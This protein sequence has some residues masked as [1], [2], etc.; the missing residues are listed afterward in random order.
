VP[1]SIGNQGTSFG[2]TEF[3]LGGGTLRAAAQI[4][5]TSGQS[6]LVVDRTTQIERIELTRD[7]C[8]GW[9]LY[10]AP[11][12]AQTTESRGRLSLRTDGAR[13]PLGAPLAGTGAGYVEIHEGTVG[14]GPVG[15][16]LTSLVRQVEA[17]L[18]GQPFATNR[19]VADVWLQLPPQK[20]GFRLRNRRVYHDRFLVQV[21][22]ATIHTSGSVG[23]DQS[24]DIVAEVPIQDSW[25]R[26][27]RFAKGVRGS[28]VTV[29]I[30]GTVSQPRIDERRLQEFSRRL[31]GEVAGRLLQE[32][33][34][35]GVN[36][37]FGAER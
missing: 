11:V 26:D 2:P 8:R 33:L 34:L 22:D 10:V 12:V 9:L 29:P 24:L 17:M 25:L 35:R 30:G 20:I 37:I 19:S 15:R 36:R 6:T 21:G 32:E 14:P 23:A 28:S 7:L 5:P 16:R 27:R 1:V 18:R 4:S 3:S 31:L 13:L